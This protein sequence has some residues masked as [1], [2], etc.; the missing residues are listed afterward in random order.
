CDFTIKS[1]DVVVQAFLHTV[2]KPIWVRLMATSLNML[3]FGWQVHEKIWEVEDVNLMITDNKNRTDPQIPA[4]PKPLVLPNCVVLKRLKDLDP[5]TV[6]PVY[7]TDKDEFVG[8]EQ[9]QQ[10]GK[11]FIDIEKLYVPRFGEEWGGVTG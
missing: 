2:M 10:R 7:D 8:V 1:D 5:S 11:Q 6:W 3:D 9:N 4:E